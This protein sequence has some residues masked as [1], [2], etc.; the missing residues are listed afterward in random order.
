MVDLEQLEKITLINKRVACVAINTSLVTPTF[1]SAHCNAKCNPCD[2]MC[3]QS[4][5][6]TVVIPLTQMTIFRALEAVSFAA[7]TFDIEADQTEIRRLFRPFCSEIRRTA[8]D[9]T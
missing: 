9:R 2:G 4:L 7:F 5:L 8:R 6:T 3:H 1:T